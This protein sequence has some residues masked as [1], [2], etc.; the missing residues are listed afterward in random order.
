[1]KDLE[2][3]SKWMEEALKEA[4]I[5]KGCEKCM[6]A[7]V[8]PTEEVMTG[9]W[10]LEYFEKRAIESAVQEELLEDLV[11]ANLAEWLEQMEDDEDSM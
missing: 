2:G 5:E 7:F 3:F 4:V 1:M 11:K 8:T 9:Y 10:N 6:I